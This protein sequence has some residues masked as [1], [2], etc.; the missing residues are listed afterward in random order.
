MDLRKRRRAAGAR[1]AGDPLGVIGVA[2]L[3]AEC[4]AANAGR[5]IFVEV[6]AVL[7]LRVSSI[8]AA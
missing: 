8:L 4:A 2:G 5:G 3:A 7:R 6:F 1:A